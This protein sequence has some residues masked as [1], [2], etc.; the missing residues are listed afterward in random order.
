VWFHH[1]HSGLQ[2]RKMPV[3]WQTKK[4]RRVVKSTLASE[5]SALLE[6]AETAVF[7]IKLLTHLINASGIEVHCYVDNENLVA[8]LHST[9]QVEDR[10][11]RID[12]AVLQDMLR[13]G[14]VSSVT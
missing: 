13:R 7:I 4:I 5:T 1:I 3:Y 8:A 11:L 10:R 12:V 6:C 14:E 2:W 9:K